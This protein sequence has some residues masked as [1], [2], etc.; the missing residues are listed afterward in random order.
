MSLDDVWKKEV[1]GIHGYWH[2]MKYKL[3]K[4]KTEKHEIQM[5]SCDEWLKADENWMSAETSWIRDV[6]TDRGGRP[7][8]KALNRKPMELFEKFIWR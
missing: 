3:L 7:V 5:L 8:C 2:I 6:A 4:C 1:A